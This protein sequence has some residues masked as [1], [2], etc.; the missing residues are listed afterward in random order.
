MR[1]LLFTPLGLTHTVTLPEEAILYA[2][3]GRPRRR[4]RASRSSRPRG[5]CRARLG[6]AGLITAR[7]G[8]RARVRAPAHG[9]RRRRRRHA[10]AQRGDRRARCRRSRPRCPTSTSLGDSW[11][12]GW[13][14]FD[15][16]GERLYGHDGNTLGQAAFL[17]IHPG[18]GVAVTLLTNGGHTHDF[19]EDLYR[20]IFAELVGRRHEARRSS[21]PDEPVEVDL[22]PYVGIYERASVRMEVLRRRGRPAA[23]HRRCS[24]R[25]PS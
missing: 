18:T 19:Y 24:V 10:A 21:P 16:N 11:G 20:E 15:W 3:G 2:R 4:R 23:A 9:R 6:P 22:T 7:V 13:I 1:D 8:G 17:R 12:L 25:W 14:R 5:G